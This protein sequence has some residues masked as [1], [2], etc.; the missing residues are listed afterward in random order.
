M[1]LSDLEILRSATKDHAAFHVLIDRHARRLLR[2]AMSLS[3]NLSDAEDICQETFTAAFRGLE[4]FDGRASVKTWLTSI[5]LRR[6]AKI[7]KKRRR[8][9]RTVSIHREEDSNNGRGAD[10][11][12]EFAS[13]L[14]VASATAISDQ[15]MDLLEAIRTLPAAFRDTILLRE[16]E[17]LSY[18][19]IAD[20][21][22]VPRGTVESRIYRARAEL[23]QKLTGY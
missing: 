6:A 15:R 9:R 18:Q 1:E 13:E 20:V 7:W 4:K 14:T 5:L 3:G 2:L 19:E 22:G 11:G 16:I 8:T 21:L 10:L 12:G 17:G 23:R